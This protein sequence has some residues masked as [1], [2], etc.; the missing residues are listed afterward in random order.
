MLRAPKSGAPFRLYIA[1]QDRVIGAVLVQEDGDKEYIIAY[2]SRRLID[3]ETRYVFIEKLCLSLYY[4]CTK[5]RP[6]LLSSTCVVACQADVIKYMLQK[7][8]LSGRIGKWAYALI[9]YDLAYESL[10]AMKGQVIADFIVDHR[11]KDEED[12]N[13]VSVC[14]WK[15]YFDGSVCSEGQGIGNV[16][17]SPNNIMY[18]T[19]VRL[20]YS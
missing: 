15:L 2:L 20:E 18:E 1:A 9:E 6:Y 13:Y 19:S 5:F 4:A 17:V 3:A 8:I 11:I 10:R 7:P 14:P 12:I 16:L